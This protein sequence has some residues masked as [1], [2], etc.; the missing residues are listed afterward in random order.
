VLADKT[1]FAITTAVECF[2]LVDDDEV[3][4]SYLQAMAKYHPSVWKGYDTLESTFYT[5][6]VVIQR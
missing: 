1:H 4:G 3:P 2:H 5:L 6:Q